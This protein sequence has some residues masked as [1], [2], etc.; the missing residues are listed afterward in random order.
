MAEIVYAQMHAHSKQS[1]ND[2]SG[3]GAFHKFIW[4]VERAIMRVVMLSPGKIAQRAGDQGIGY[5]AITDH[6]TVP[7]FNLGSEYANR[8]IMGEEW[9]QHKGHANFVHL[10]QPVDPEAGYYASKNPKEPREFLTAARLAKD[11]GA[12]VS[13]NHPF[14]RD[15]WN[16]GDDSY[17][18]ANAI[19]IWNGPWN[20]ENM[21]ALSKWQLLLE[22]G[23][24]IFAMAGNDFHVRKLFNLNRQLTA[25]Q[26]IRN[27]DG[28]MKALHAGKYS[29]TL[30]TVSP[31]IFLGRRGEAL[32]FHIHNYRPH[33]ELV[34][35]SMRRH[36]RIDQPEAKGK[37]ALNEFESFVRL[38]LWQDGHPMSF[39][40]P[41]FLDK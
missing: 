40:N 39:S 22:S 33:L 15:F 30:D 4:P 14:K 24:K 12:F 7:E 27:Q 28:L 3:E 18:A 10:K 1:V 35:Y 32:T 20:E 16:W 8:L 31:V 34:A 41:V 26:G 25:F 38:E 9:G 6:N 11:Q 5:V 36:V 17:R 37:L 29:L 13:I 19:E 21:K 23:L 2:L